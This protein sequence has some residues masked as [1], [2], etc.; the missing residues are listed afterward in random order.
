MK[1]LLWLLWLIEIFLTA[2]TIRFTDLFHVKTLTRQPSKLVNK[3]SWLQAVLKHCINFSEL[4][5]LPLCDI[6]NLKL[7]CDVWSL[8]L[9]LYTK[10][11][12][13]IFLSWKE[14]LS[15]SARC[16]AVGALVRLAET[17][18]FISF[19]SERPQ[20]LILFLGCFSTPLQKRCVCLKRT[21]RTPG[22]SALLETG[23]LSLFPAPATD[24]PTVLGKVYEISFVKAASM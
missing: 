4:E 20:Y 5:H 6:Y 15:T 13:R 12:T 11:Q 14:F 19:F 1:L 22:W 16:S 18:T 9:F 7:S 3:K 10:N 23:T 2:Q 17:Q 24:P 8:E 21:G